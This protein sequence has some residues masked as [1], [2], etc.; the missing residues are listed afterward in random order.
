MQALGLEDTDPDGALGWYAAIV[1]EVTAITSGRPASGDGSEAFARL[2]A[3][4]SPR[5]TA[6]LPRRWSPP[7]RATPRA[8][9][10][11]GRLERGC[12]ALRRDRDDGGDDRE[13]APPPARAR[14]AAR[15]RRGRPAARRHC[16]EE[17]L[18]LEPAAAVLDRYA[19]RDVELGGARDRAGRPRHALAR[20]RESRPGG[21]RR[22][23]PLRRAAAE[24]STSRSRS[25]MGRT[26]V[27]A[28][29]S[30]GWRRADRAS[31]RRWSGC[32]AF[33][34]DPAPPE[35]RR[36][37]SS[38]ASRRRVH[39][40]WDSGRIACGGLIAFGCSDRR[41]D[42]RRRPLG[43]RPPQRH[44]RDRSAPTTSPRTCSTG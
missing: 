40:L 12:A 27:S 24:R 44:P 11:A 22:S 8:H 5:S 33:A 9:A 23:R 36:E 3:A 28:C 37:A 15:A 30:P 13:R 16:V 39:V 4:S 10:G 29:T 42:R 31:R 38:S 1:A 17:S 20:G 35:R 21:L 6:T 32:R 18:R 43:H 41:A 7:R 34:L 26:S 2:R 14:R 25:P 19:T